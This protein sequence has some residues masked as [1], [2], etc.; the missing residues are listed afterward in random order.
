[1]LKES[2]EH[3][4]L[5]RLDEA[6]QGYR[7]HLLGQPDDPEALHLLGLLRHQRGATVEAEDLLTRAHALAPE[8]AGIELSLGT[9]KFQTGDFDAARAHYEEALSL[10]PN[11]GTAHSGLGQ[12]ALMQ[13]ER[14]K[15]EQHFRIAL[16]AGEDAQA[17][18]GLGSLLLEREDLEAALRHLGR[19]ADL[20]PNDPIIQM[21]LGRAFLKRGTDSFAEKAFENALRVK[22]DLQPARE[23]LA[24]LTLRAKR[25]REAET[26]FRA[27]MSV[28]GS[29]AAGHVGLG[30]VARA[31]GRFDDAIVEYRAALAIDPKQSAPAR[32]LAWSLAQRARN[33]EA[34]AA[35]DDYLALV[36]GDHEVRTARADMLMLI[37]RL[38]QAAADWRAIAASNPADMQAQSR[39]AL[40]DE[41]LGLLDAAS[42]QADL[43]LRA[44]PADVEMLLVRIRA[45]MRGGDDAEARRLLDRFDLASLTEGQRRLYWNYL[46]RLHDRAGDAGE[47][48]R[49]FVEA[50]QGS[51]VSMPSLEPPHPELELALTDPVGAPWP[52][53]P[54]LL[55]GTPGSGVERV[56]ALLADQPGLT[57]LRDRIGALQR[58]DDFN[59]PRFPFYCGEL[60]ETDRAALR[61]RYLGPL[62]A[63]GV[64][65]DRPIVDWLPRWDA[66]LLALVRRAFPGT[67]L[68]I[69]ERDP[70]DAL[71]NWLAFGWARGFPCLDPLAF[72]EWLGRARDHLHY[73]DALDEPRRLV[74]GADA[75]LDDPLANGGALARFLGLD[76]LQPGA[77]HAASSRGLGG[78]PVRFPRG[79]FERYRDALAEPFAK[80]EASS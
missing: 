3:H 34:I 36:P 59:Q 32:A 16:R 42:A 76:A 18:A 4:R 63:A 74:V 65:I 11:I 28:P 5:G 64:R 9:L 31:E 37:G 54:V 23:A 68:V 49:C 71:V 17:L 26:H 50:Q 35:Y 73:A 47:A 51:P 78:L 41:H 22:P 72:S 7:E 45:A 6:E 30:D 19:A 46:G 21:T 44:Q 62:R 1:M 66:H 14:D 10:D 40:I 52:E 55:L 77:N 53:A 39:I 24:A 80:L 8:K 13:G 33:D 69:V 61:D 48:V 2:I 67:R 20:A 43:V 56:A 75:P 12:I 25:P 79:H 15:A 60:S 58:V 27:L 29:E 70:R 38:P 57:V